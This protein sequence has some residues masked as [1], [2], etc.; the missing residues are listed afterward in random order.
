MG[1]DYS[2]LGPG[3]DLDPSAGPAFDVSAG[4]AFEVS[5]GPAFEVSA[6]PAFD[7]RA[8][9]AFE[10]RAGPAFEV[11]VFSVFGSIPDCDVSCLAMLNSFKVSFFTILVKNTSQTKNQAF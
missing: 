4:P 7:V 8:G 6:G 3:P 9:P 1:A 2:S 5:A 11:R 10:V